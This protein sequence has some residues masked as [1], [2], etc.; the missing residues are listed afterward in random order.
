[1]KDGK[2]SRVEDDAHIERLLTDGEERKDYWIFAKDPSV[3]ALTDLLNRALDKPAEQE[4]AV[5][6]SGTLKIRWQDE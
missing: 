3:Q 4:R 6:L 1:L 2:C 5:K